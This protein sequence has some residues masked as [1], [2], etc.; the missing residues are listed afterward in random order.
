MYF[1]IIIINCIPQVTSKRA[2][3]PARLAPSCLMNLS[4]VRKGLPKVPAKGAK[5]SQLA[6]ANQF[7]NNKKD[8]THLEKSMSS[9]IRSKLQE[10]MKTQYRYLVRKRPVWLSN[11]W[12]L[13]EKDEALQ[14]Y[15]SHRLT[16]IEGRI[17]GKRLPRNKKTISASEGIRI[18][19]KGKSLT[20][21]TRW[22]MENLVT[23]T[24]TTLWTKWVD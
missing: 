8:S 3:Y 2:R 6:N 21:S 5:K 24:F 16:L 14:T 23:R 13:I 22:S 12:I 18:L 11:N 10:S 20:W 9:L 19:W 4:I 7:R 17:T 1:P 15:N